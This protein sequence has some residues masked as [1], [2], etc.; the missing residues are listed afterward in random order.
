M[1]LFDRNAARGQNDLPLSCEHIQALYRPVL[2]NFLHYATPTNALQ[3][4]IS[5][6]EAFSEDCP[7]LCAT[8]EFTPRAAHYVRT[9][10]RTNARDD[11]PVEI[12]SHLLLGNM[13]PSSCRERLQSLGV[14]AVVNVSTTCANHFEADLRYLNI[15][16][17]DSASADLTVWF[18]TANEFIDSVQR[19]GGRVLVHCHAGRSRSVTICL[20]YLM[21]TYGW[22]LDAAYEHVRARRDVIDP[23]LNF[24]RQLQDY[25]RR[26]DAPSAPVTEM[27]VAPTEMAVSLSSPEMDAS[28]YA[29]S[30]SSPAIAPPSPSAGQVFQFP[31]SAAMTNVGGADALQGGTTAKETKIVPEVTPPTSATEIQCYFTFSTTGFTF[32]RSAF[33]MTPLTLPS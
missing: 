17:N 29:S 23:N 19:E 21:R 13:V 33:A 5:G 28:A 3:N 4:R 24:M 18:A 22:T 12:L 14:T 30:A 31:S 20:A 16:V 1:T 10:S 27:A 6:Y 32:P 15:P 2:T 7:L 25:R 9:E 26:L 11:Q 8:H